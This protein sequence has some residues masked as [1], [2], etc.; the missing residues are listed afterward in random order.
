MVSAKA[1]VRPWPGLRTCL[2]LELLAVGDKAPLKFH[3]GPRTERPQADTE[4]AKPG[5]APPGHG[6]LRG[7]CDLRR[8]L[9]DPLF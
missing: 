7:I 9:I 6:S 8:Q 3:Q 4:V 5:G 2:V 1:L